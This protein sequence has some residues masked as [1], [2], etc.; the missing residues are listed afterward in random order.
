MVGLNQSRNLS[1]W[2][3]KAQVTTGMRVSLEDVTTRKAISTLYTT[4]SDITDQEEG[5]VQGVRPDPLLGILLFLAKMAK[6]GIP[7]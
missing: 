2:L 6:Q 4:L 5:V 1:A 3:A 7:K